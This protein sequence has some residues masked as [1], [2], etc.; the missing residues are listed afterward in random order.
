MRNCTL[1]VFKKLK[2]PLLSLFCAV[3]I[4]LLTIF[5][6]RF[7]CPSQSKFYSCSDLNLK[8][9]GPAKL[10]L[11]SFGNEILQSTTPV[12]GILLPGAFNLTL[13][14]SQFYLQ[15]CYSNY[16]G[17]EKLILMFRDQSFPVICKFDLIDKCN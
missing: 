16:F 9:A 3:L 10:K 15:N 5:M 11:C 12:I 6:K 2:F 8:H 7:Y 14:N 1:L 13:N 17:S 4:K